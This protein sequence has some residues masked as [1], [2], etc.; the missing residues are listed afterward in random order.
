MKR[1]GFILLAVMALSSCRDK[2]IP[3][4]SGIEI[5]LPVK[6][7]EQDFFAMD[8]LHLMAS[9]QQLHQK[10]PGFLPDYAQHILG[11]PPVSD[12]GNQVLELTKKFIRDYKPIKDSADKVFSR[13]GPIE[14][15]VKKGLQFVKYYF[16]SYKLP[17]SLVTFIGP[18]DAF[19]EASLGGY[20]D[21]ITAGGLAVGLQLHLGKDFSLYKSDMGQ[22]L[23]PDYVSRRF[24]PDYIAVNCMKNIIDDLYPEKL[25]GKPLV[26]Q[27][28][29]KGKRL[30]VLEKIMPYTPDTLRTGYTDY[31][32]KGCYSN[33]GNI[34]N[35]FLTNNLLYNTEPGLIK[36][37]ISDGP[38]TPTL[39]EGSPG[40]IGLFIGRQIVKKYLSK[41][42]SVTLPELLQMD[43]KQLFQESKYKPG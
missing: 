25:T 22:A 2:E 39:G 38:H 37:Y 3:D 43:A 9:L 13:F 18:M 11:L 21:V 6:R 8:T 14:N 5:T 23:Y 26:E 36:E 19:Y 16:P 40:F 4:V 29:E 10:Y 17:A 41:N 7:F 27:F 30:Y 33:E 31:Q 32:L 1:T 28:V 20:G 35:F 15:D 24:T 42:P 12:T 34:W